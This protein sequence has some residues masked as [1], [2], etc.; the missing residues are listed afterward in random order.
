MVKITVVH[1]F[2]VILIHRH[3]RSPF[4]YLG[5]GLKLCRSS[6]FLGIPVVINC[7]YVVVLV[8]LIEHLF[9]ICNVFLALK[10]NVG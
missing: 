6:Q 3:R 10:L 8:K 4:P 9:H 5:E 2:V 7:V 1:F